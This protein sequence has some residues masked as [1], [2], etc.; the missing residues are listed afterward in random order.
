MRVLINCENDFEAQ[1][2]VGRLQNEGIK[3]VVLNEYIHNVWPMSSADTF[4][5][6][7]AVNEEDY[8][9]AV[10]AIS[11]DADPTEEADQ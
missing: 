5:L 3:A 4:T 11:V 7:V 1:L 8:N 10:R 6:Q 9:Q 2:I